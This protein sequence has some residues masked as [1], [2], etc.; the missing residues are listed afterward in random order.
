MTDN[1]RSEVIIVS[2]TIA[3]IKGKTKLPKS[4]LKRVLP[5]NRRAS[6]NITIFNTKITIARSKPKAASSNIPRPLTPPAA[7]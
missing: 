6:T 5:K 4:T 1:N 2:G 7:I 3:M